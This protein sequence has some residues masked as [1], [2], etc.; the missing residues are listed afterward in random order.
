MTDYPMRDASDAPPTPAFEL[1]TTLPRIPR[2]VATAPVECRAGA[3]A[4]YHLPWRS[5]ILNA[6]ILWAG[7]RFIYLIFT[8]LAAGLAQ[9][10]QTKGSGFFGVWQRFDTNWY[11]S[12]AT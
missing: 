4:S 5:I 3:P 2:A 12:I 8:Y 10:Q 7:T 11:L 1:D 9:I 6:V